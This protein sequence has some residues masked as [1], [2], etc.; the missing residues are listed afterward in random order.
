[1]NGATTK[2]LRSRVKTNRKRRKRVVSAIPPSFLAC[3]PTFAA[4]AMSALSLE[5]GAGSSA[6][7]PTGGPPGKAKGPF[8]FHFPKSGL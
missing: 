8:E 2:V 3:R 1:M 7:L 4:L 5:A 6:V